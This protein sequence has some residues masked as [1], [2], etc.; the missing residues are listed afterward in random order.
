MVELLSVSPRESLVKLAVYSAGI[1][2]SLNILSRALYFI[3]IY[4][5]PSKLHRYLH[6]TDGKPAWALITG[7]T[8]GIG[9]QLV[10]K[11]AAIGFNLVIH[12]RNP[13]KLAAVREELAKDFPA[14]QVRSIIADGTA[15]AGGG[16]A[17]PTKANSD[18]DRQETL[19]NFD[20]IAESLSDLNLTVLINNAG[21][22]N[23]ESP[24]YEYLQEM[25]ASKLTRTHNLN[26]L[27]PITLTS[28]L[29]GQLMRNAP[30]LV[31]NIGSLAE[32][33]MPMLAAYSPAKAYLSKATEVLAREIAMQGRSDDVEILMV[34]PGEV[35]GTVYNKNTP[36]LFEPD[37]ETMAKAILAR[38]GCGRVIVDGY[39]PHALQS[40]ALGLTPGFVRERALR[41]V[42][43]TR[44]EL[45]QKMLKGL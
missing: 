12:G 45:D 32:T 41:D 24:V 9:K 29:L 23:V 42:I 31:L 8:D 10:H 17:S 44:Q 35:C 4:L 38:I 26:A 37:A 2:T 22:G 1:L 16:F 11:L 15:L 27:F 30:C 5:K 18:K 33:G 39:L 7:A 13:A 25:A 19:V 21:S 6:E 36:S 28:K 40:V 34:R 43:K 14:C 3:S 20:A